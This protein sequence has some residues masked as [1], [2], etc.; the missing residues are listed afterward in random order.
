MEP[1]AAPIGE[2]ILR[3]L[4]TEQPE[5]LVDMA[6]GAGL[7]PADLTYI[8]E[9]LGYVV[10]ATMAMPAL[11]HLARHAHPMVREGVVLGATQLGT[12]EAKALV[13]DIADNDPTASVR[14]VARDSLEWQDDGVPLHSGE[15]SVALSV[16]TAQQFVLRTADGEFEPDD[17]IVDAASSNGGQR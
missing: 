15:H 16:V 12:T 17:A 2:N 4:A 11:Q 6:F 14:G 1:L 13:L 5:L 10:D 3:H 7:G 9:A 8:G